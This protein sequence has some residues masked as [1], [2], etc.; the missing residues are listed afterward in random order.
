MNRAL[1]LLGIIATVMIASVGCAAGVGPLEPNGSGQLCISSGPDESVAYGEL[2]DLP[3][4]VD[5]TVVL[6]S[7]ETVGAAGA[8]FYVLPME[9]TTSQ[10]TFSL[11]DPPKVWEQRQ[12]A[13]G[14][15]ID[16]GESANIMAVF[17]PLGG[18]EIDVTELVIGYHE[19]SGRTYEVTSSLRVKVKSACF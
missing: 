15:A 11:D 10:G 7:L 16:P 3:G 5:E 6:D 4:D 9:G 13:E 18:S 8:D 2:V 17:P 12:R 14:Y 1:G 19:Q